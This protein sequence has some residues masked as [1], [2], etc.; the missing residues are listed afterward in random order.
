MLYV[1]YV[2]HMASKIASHGR[3]GIHHGVWGL[4]TREA[5]LRR[6]ILRYKDTCR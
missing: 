1:Q 6:L 5:L 3:V 2:L 4:L